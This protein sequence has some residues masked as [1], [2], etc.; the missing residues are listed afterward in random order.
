MPGRAAAPVPPSDADTTGAAGGLAAMQ[1]EFAAAMAGRG[2][3]A[4]AALLARRAGPRASTRLGIYRNNIAS[5]L[6]RALEGL[7]PALVRLMGSEFFNRLARDYARAHPPA[8]GRLLEYGFDFPDFVAGY[9]AARGYPWFADVGRLELAWHRAYLAA[10]A[11]PL[12]AEDLVGVPPERMA[13]LVL[14]PH[15]SCRMLASRYPVSRIWRVALEEEETERE[16]EIA[17]G[18]EWLLVV[19][20]GAEVEVRTLEE[21]GFAFLGALAQGR[22]LGA[23][24]ESVCAVDREFDLQSHVAGLLTGDT[25]S[26]FRLAP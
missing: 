23:A 19:R 24:Y 2:D 21:S 10:E 16:V 9:E 14:E 20:P 6:V 25:F 5:A 7:Y 1:A 22:S 15:P 4:V 8:H 26:G 13:D 12:R 18:A 3:D 11:V 17:G